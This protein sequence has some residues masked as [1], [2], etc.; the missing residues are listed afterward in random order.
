MPHAVDKEMLSEMLQDMVG[1]MTRG[2]TLTEEEAV[3]LT[4]DFLGILCP[5]IVPTQTGP[6][7]TRIVA[8]LAEEV[9]DGRTR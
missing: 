7:C 4:I 1:T 5:C 3:D 2:R 6:V 8:Q 9:K